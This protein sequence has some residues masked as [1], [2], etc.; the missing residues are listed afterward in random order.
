MDISEG[1]PP[2]KRRTKR[3]VTRQ[4]D[5]ENA[6]PCGM[7]VPLWFDLLLNT[8][9]L[10]L[11]DLIML[12]R[13][14]LA[15]AASDPLRRLIKDKVWS[16]FGDIHERYWDR[17]SYYGTEIEFGQSWGALTRLH[18]DVSMILF[19]PGYSN[20]IQWGVFSSKRLL[21]KAFKGA[22]KFVNTRMV[23]YARDSHI[24]LITVQNYTKRIY[25]R[26][27]TLEQVRTFVEGQ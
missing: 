6:T 26:G 17:L 22:Y 16:A 12:K 18:D 1:E 19:D 21:W 3:R 24:E 15:F 11:R 23:Y 27:V 13:T 25:I 4:P 7:N 9:H 10:T 20:P 8:K 2:F 14:C 5:P